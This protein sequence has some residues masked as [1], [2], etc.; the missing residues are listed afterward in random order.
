MRLANILVTAVV[1]RW[2]RAAI[3]NVVQGVSKSK[4]VCLPRSKCDAAVAFVPDEPVL[5]VLTAS[6]AVT[7]GMVSMILARKAARSIGPALMS[8]RG[9]CDDLRTSAVEA[10]DGSVWSRSSQGFGTREEGA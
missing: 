7:A 4:L 5:M 9:G 6:R 1:R 2:S 3:D 10:D 8:W